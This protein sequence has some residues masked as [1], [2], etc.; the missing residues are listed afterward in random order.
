MSLHRH[1][2]LKKGSVW[3]EQGRGRSAC[4]GGVSWGC[5]RQLWQIAWQPKRTVP[6]PS[7]L[8]PENTVLPAGMS[9]P[10]HPAHAPAYKQRTHCPFHT[11]LSGLGSCDGWQTCPTLLVAPWRGST[12][13]RHHPDKDTARSTSG[14]FY[15]IR[16]FNF[17]FHLWLTPALLHSKDSS[18]HP[19][20]IL[21]VPWPQT[22]WR[23]GC[24][25]MM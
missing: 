22:V 2:F 7:A 25:P 21:G 20:T 3:P 17:I 4:P 14:P 10:H 13:R 8:N 18:S 24:I 16:I 23:T 11:K 19:G 9:S 5:D 6:C 1:L 15:A 12:G